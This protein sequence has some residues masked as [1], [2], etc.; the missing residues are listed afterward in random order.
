M[1]EPK[2][3]RHWQLSQD[4][5]NITWLSIDVADR[6]V[7]V[8]SYAVLEE[9]SD[10]VLEIRNNGACT[11]V[12]FISNK[13]SGFI[14]GADVKEIS[15]VEDPNEA[16][17]FMHKAQILFSMIEAL[18]IPVVAAIDGLCLGGGLELAL[19]CHYRIASDASGTQLGLPEVKL[20]IHPGFG[21][22]VRVLRLLG[23]FQGMNF[24]LQGRNVDA[25]A[26]KK[27]GLVNDVVALRQLRRAAIYF[28]QHQPKKTVKTARWSTLLL[29]PP[30]LR[31]IVTGFLVQ[32]LKKKVKQDQYPAPYAV[33]GN[34]VEV[35]A[36]KE[37]AFAEEA[38]SVG[39]LILTP[40]CH[41]LFRV[42]S[43]QEKLK[44]KAK[45][46]EFKVHH[47]HIIGAGVMGGD[48][49]AWCAVQGLQVS[50]QDP[51]P[52]ALGSALART[53]TLAQKLLKRKHL[54]EAA[55]DRL[56][57]DPQG[58]GLSKADLIL[59]A[60]V[61]NLAVKHEIFKNIDLKAKDSAILATNTS[62][63]SLSE[64]AAV[65]KNPGRLI[66]IHFFNP[67][68]KMPLVEVVSA[69]K[70]DPKTALCGA[71]FVKQIK[72]LPLP[73][74]DGHGFLVNQILGGYFEAGFKALE[75]G[76]S[77]NAVDKAGR[78]LGMP[79][80]PIELA[81]RVG[82][83]VC[84]AAAPYLMPASSEKALTALQAKVQQGELGYKTQ[85]G[86]YRYSGEK[87]IREKDKDTV[88]SASLKKIQRNLFLSMLSRAL[89]CLET[90]IVS[91]VDELDAGVIFGAGFPP[92]RGGLLQYAKTFDKNEL[93]KDLADYRKIEITALEKDSAWQQLW[94]IG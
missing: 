31:S 4:E 42:F 52:Q 77:L 72:K 86:F 41:N 29:E 14:L 53:Y 49:A 10:I 32:G 73:V 27:M 3:Y 18:R 13:P 54:I 47:I 58:Y 56:C 75:T 85:K 37:K 69:E 66:G 35:G 39:R 55:M 19:A 24:I 83:D 12:V 28:I 16:V 22:S 94:A 80:G 38:A 87:L 33:L 90:Q 9:L 7:N 64:I 30:L 44:E 57:P 48:I 23:I 17:D 62:S 45:G 71:I 91:G 11:G 5:H 15:Q 82:L 36:L 1:S 2:K 51:S 26:A 43:L 60:A 21:G 61:E 34:W 8:L 89:I 84:L 88:N 50:L 46:G 92:F 65:L 6:E 76:Q 63:L 25:Y 40:T 79:M 93:A 67:V 59:E 70:T 74:R 20:G 81:D 68:S 78:N